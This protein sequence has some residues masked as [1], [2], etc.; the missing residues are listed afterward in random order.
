I[1]AERLER[2]VVERAFERRG[3]DALAEREEGD[4][5]A[6]A[7][8]DLLRV[9][10]VD[11]AHADHRAERR[12]TD[13]VFDGTRDDAEDLPAPHPRVVAEEAVHRVEDGG[14]S[15]ELELGRARRL[16]VSEL[17]DDA[18]LAIDGEER[19]ALVVA[20][21]VV[22]RAERLRRVLLRVRRDV[23]QLLAVGRLD[24]L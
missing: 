5:R 4:V 10:S 14:I 9:V 6:R 24:R 17:R 3:R 7:L 19:I 22:E 20:R 13:L 21:L 2:V 11:E 1:A 15:A 8:A 12:L 16:G 18:S 23:L